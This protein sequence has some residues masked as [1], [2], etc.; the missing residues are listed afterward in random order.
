MN[1]FIKIGDIA[2]LLSTLKVTTSS[3]ASTP[4]AVKKSTNGFCIVA[5]IVV[6]GIVSYELYLYLKKKKETEKNRSNL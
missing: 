6:A 1:E 5:G 3:V 4:S 2:N